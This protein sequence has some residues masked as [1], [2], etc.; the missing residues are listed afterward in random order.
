M[1]AGLVVATT[2]FGEVGRV[3]HAV[4]LVILRPSQMSKS[5]NDKRKEAEAKN[6]P[7]QTKQQKN[8]GKESPCCPWALGWEGFE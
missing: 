6:G 1:T 4:P 5:N 3:A 8:A 7:K 2:F